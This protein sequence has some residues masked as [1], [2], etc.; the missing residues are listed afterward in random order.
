MNGDIEKSEAF[1]EF[2]GGY[3]PEGQVPD[4]LKTD[5]FNTIDIIEL[6]ADVLD[7]F[8][9]KFSQTEISFL[10]GFEDR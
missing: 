10:E 2:L 3:H 7:L 1:L 4:H 5:I 8:V 6:T 9:V